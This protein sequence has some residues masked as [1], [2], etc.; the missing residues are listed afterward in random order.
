MD[1]VLVFLGCRDAARFGLVAPLSPLLSPSSS[2][3]SRITKHHI[4]LSAGKSIDSHTWHNSCI[5]H[6]CKNT[7]SWLGYLPRSRSAGECCSHGLEVRIPA[8]R[9]SESVMS[10]VPPSVLGANKRPAMTPKSKSAKASNEAVFHETKSSSRQSSG[11][12]ITIPKV[13]N[14]LWTH[15]WKISSWIMSTYF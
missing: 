7:S 1:A 3:S 13:S 11:R 15:R 12:T 2:S 14:R 6:W 10:T 5:E 9:Y 8:Y 4:E